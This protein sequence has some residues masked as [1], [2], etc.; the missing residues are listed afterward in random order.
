MH[1]V[2]FAFQRLYEVA[3]LVEQ[4]AGDAGLLVVAARTAEQR[5][6]RGV[7]KPGHCSADV[8]QKEHCTCS[9]TMDR[10]AV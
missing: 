6:Q 10:R 7:G 4:H 9:G 5:T 2:F 3:V 8:H 1:G